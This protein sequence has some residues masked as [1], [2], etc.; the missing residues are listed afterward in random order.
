MADRTA[1]RTRGF[2]LIELLVV[3]SIIGILVGFMLP[4][5]QNVR[6]SALVASQFE[7]LQLVASHVL[8]VTEPETPLVNALDSAHAIVAAVQK[9]RT[10]PDPAKVAATLQDLQ[11]GEADLRQVL[12]ALKNPASSQVPEELE[13]Y[14]DL[15]HDLTTLS[16]ETRQL[17]AHL[18]HL[19]ELAAP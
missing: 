1:I 18:G 3:I 15:K 14:L 19:L 10:L 8:L 6:E 13:A 16:A 12:R 11:R 2:T 17:E 9:E 7:S 4:A 5:V